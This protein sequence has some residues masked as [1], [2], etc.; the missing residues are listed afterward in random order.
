MIEVEW[1]GELEVGFNDI[2]SAKRFIVKVGKV[3]APSVDFKIN[4]LLII[5]PQ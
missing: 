4:N 2:D 5:P 3:A 1:T